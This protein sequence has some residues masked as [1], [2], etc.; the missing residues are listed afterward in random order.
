LTAAAYWAS[1]ELKYSHHMIKWEIPL[2]VILLYMRQNSYNRNPN[3]MTLEDKDAIDAGLY[4]I[5]KQK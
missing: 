5:N 4:D 1:T 3:Q 2:A